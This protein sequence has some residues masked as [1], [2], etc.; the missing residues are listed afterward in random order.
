MRY[1]YVWNE[2]FNNLDEIAADPRCAVDKLIFFE[3]LKLWP[4][5]QAIKEVPD[6]HPDDIVKRQVGKTR[7]TEEQLRQ[8]LRQG[9]PPKMAIWKSVKGRDLLLYAL[10]ISKEQYLKVYKQVALGPR[11]FNNCYETFKAIG[12]PVA[13]KNFYK[14]IKCYGW[15]VKTAALCDFVYLAFGRKYKSQKAVLAE[16]PW[17]IFHYPSKKTL[18]ERLMC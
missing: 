5:E 1:H 17:V 6:W 3:R 10:N 2:W 14:R 18:A 7:C 15:E 16:A 13:Y 12:T 4:I 11:H 9:F 8:R